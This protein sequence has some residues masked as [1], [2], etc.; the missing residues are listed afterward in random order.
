M[1][2]LFANTQFMRKVHLCIHIDECDTEMTISFLCWPICDFRGIQSTGKHD[3]GPVQWT[4]NS[5]TVPSH[6]TKHQGGRG[7]QWRSSVA[8]T[9]SL[10]KS[11]TS[12]CGKVDEE[13]RDNKE[14]L[15]S[16]RGPLMLRLSHPHWVQSIRVIPTSHLQFL[17]LPDQLNCR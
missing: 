10:E 6:S 2:A 15:L 7:C 8:V 1:P 16:H 9:A 13:G 11:M 3:T 14:Q 5:P 17:V 12:R 4:N